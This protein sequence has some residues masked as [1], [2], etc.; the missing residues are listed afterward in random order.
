MPTV[1]IHEA[2]TH[3]SRL[4]DQAAKGQGFVI[5]KAGKP[6]AQVTA[7]D[8]PPHKTRLGFMAGNIQV[9]DDFDRMAEAEISG[10]FGL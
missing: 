7:I 1:N 9:P 10:L 8:A 3:L 4:V 2:K 6:M 5:A